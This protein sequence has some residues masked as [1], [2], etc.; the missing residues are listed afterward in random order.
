MAHAITSERNSCIDDCLACHRICV[1][2]ASHCLELGAE[3]ADAAHIRTLLDCEELCA[4][5]ADFMLRGSPMH[6]VVCG[7]CALACERCAE[8]CEQV[9]ADDEE[10]R[11]CADLCRRCAESCRRI[12]R[13][14]QA[15]AG[16]GAEARL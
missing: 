7:A 10:M 5:S 13:A 2:T 4:V 6:G 8:S 3:H 15:D 16:R 11:S 14:A 12:D 9:A 1:E